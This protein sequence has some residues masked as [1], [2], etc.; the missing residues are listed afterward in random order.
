[1][2]ALCHQTINLTGTVIREHR[3]LHLHDV[4]IETHHGS[5]LGVFRREGLYLTGGLRYQRKEQVEVDLLGF[6]YAFCQAITMVGEVAC[7]NGGEVHLLPFLG[8]TINDMI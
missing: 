4:L 6:E 7:Q 3:H 1:M 2:D 8:I 5:C